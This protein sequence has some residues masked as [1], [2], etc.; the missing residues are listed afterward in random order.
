MRTLELHT[1]NGSD[2]IEHLCDNAPALNRFRS[3][4]HELRNAMRGLRPRGPTAARLH[5][6]LTPDRR[7]IS[8]G[9]VA[10]NDYVIHIGTVARSR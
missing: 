9:V 3:A 1:P 2:P 5:S 7:T 10:V 6:A 8:A 4:M